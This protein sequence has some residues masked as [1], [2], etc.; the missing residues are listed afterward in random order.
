M[1]THASFESLKSRFKDI[2]HLRNISNLL[3]WDQSTYMPEQGEAARG[4]QLA[5]IGQMV[6]E[7][8]SDPSVG[9]WIASSESFCKS[10][11]E[12]SL[13]FSYWRFYPSVG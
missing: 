4:Q 3:S 2:F 9:E 7:R 1:N 11:G 13:D 6:H 5:I 12:G 10:Q 8:T